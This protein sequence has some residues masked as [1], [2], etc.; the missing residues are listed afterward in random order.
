MK[1]L[2]LL[3][4]SFRNQSKVTWHSKRIDTGAA[5]RLSHW[6]SA[7]KKDSNGIEKVKVFVFGRPII[8]SSDWASFK[9][10]DSYISNWICKRYLVD[11]WNWLN[12]LSGAFVIVILDSDLQQMHVVTDIAGACPVYALNP[13]CF[14]SV[15]FS[16][17][18][19]LLI[20]RGD[21]K[22]L[23][24]ISI[25]EFLTRG[26]ISAPYSSWK[27]VT[28]L[29]HASI[30]T[31][32][33]KKDNYSVRQYFSLEHDPLRNYQLLLD[34]FIQSVESAVDKRTRSELGNKV[35]LLS[36]GHDSRIIA[37]Q[38]ARKGSALTLY[39]VWNRECEIV[40]QIVDALEI[41]HKFLKRGKD[42]YSLTAKIAPQL[43]GP[44]SSFSNAHFNLIKDLY[45]E[46]FSSCDTLLTGCY[47][48]WLFKGIAHNRKRSRLL[49]RVAPVFTFQ[50]FDF[51]YFGAISKLHPE[52]E[53]AVLSRFDQQFSGTDRKNR[54]AVELRR[55]FPIFQEETSATRLS[56]QRLHE[57]EP[58]F[59][60][61]DVLTAYLNI[62]WQ[63]KKNHRFFESACAALAPAVRDIPH[64]STGKKV[65]QSNYFF[66]VQKVL[67]RIRKAFKPISSGH[68]KL[69]YFGEGSWIDFPSYMD[70]NELIQA[71]WNSVS[72]E[73]RDYVTDLLEVNLWNMS[74]DEIRYIDYHL[75]YNALTFCCWFD[76][77]FSRERYSETV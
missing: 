25:Y 10:E 43:T 30:H 32:E 64:S 3:N 1:F 54:D 67:M 8:E 29:S 56:L 46:A 70:Q 73:S 9:G 48:D 24:S 72:K 50:P 57:W 36:G 71:Q 33:L 2:R 68:S 45:P 37:A 55:L 38:M 15:E 52:Y 75:F 11:Q 35:V 51:H 60:D 27:D 7:S 19:D 21:E 28:A 13:Q 65:E 34:N 42:Y 4:D 74:A 23:D 39:D 59:I 69:S 63:M 22:R 58:P 17:H 61:R 66:F 47:A 6:R 44:Y 49:G 16:T 53:K 14:S 12:S 40:E 31:W 62:P 41:G 26:S 5:S 77:R 76:S 20:N 18:P